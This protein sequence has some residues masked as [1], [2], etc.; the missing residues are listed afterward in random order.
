MVC[1][2]S[3]GR[4]THHISLEKLKPNFPNYAFG[5]LSQ[6]NFIEMCSLEEITQEIL[7]IL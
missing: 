7:V 2:M 1:G 4:S 6:K 3:I 5:K